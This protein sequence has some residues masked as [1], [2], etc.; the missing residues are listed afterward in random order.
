MSYLKLCE[1]DRIVC[2]EALDYQP[3][4]VVLGNRY[5]ARGPCLVGIPGS[6]IVVNNHMTFLGLVK[7]R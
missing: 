4:V 5:E 7:D 1:S 6:K 3:L 2:R